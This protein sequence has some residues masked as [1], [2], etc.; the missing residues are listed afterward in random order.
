[1]T[2]TTP[3]RRE[4]VV[5]RQP[6]PFPNTGFHAPACGLPT[7]LAVQSTLRP[8]LFE[9]AHLHTVAPRG[10]SNWGMNRRSSFPCLPVL[11]VGNA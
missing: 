3:I 1:M 5:T 9:P 10:H 2:G 11:P 4:S 6:A 7:L 8:L